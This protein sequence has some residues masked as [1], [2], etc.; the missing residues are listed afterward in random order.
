M[1]SYSASNKNSE[2]EEYAKRYEQI[3]KRRGSASMRLW[4]KIPESRSESVSSNE[5][6]RYNESFDSSETVISPPSEFVDLKRFPLQTYD[7]KGKI[8]K[9]NNFKSVEITKIN[10]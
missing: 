9:K 3:G 2:L 10:L 6:L 7:V 4:Q 1:D 8:Q 5:T